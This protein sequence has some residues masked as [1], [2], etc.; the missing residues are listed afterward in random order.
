VIKNSRYKIQ[1][2]N[3]HLQQ[4]IIIYGTNTKE[5]IMSAFFVCVSHEHSAPFQIPFNLSIVHTDKENR[6]PAKRKAS[7]AISGSRRLC[8]PT[9][10]YFPVLV[11]KDT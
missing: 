4:K 1:T 6:L 5:E 2:G 7:A 9:G 11:R 10:L 8:D 3:Y